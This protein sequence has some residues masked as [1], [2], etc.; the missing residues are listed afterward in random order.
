MLINKDHIS[1]TYH[2][3]IVE[4]ILHDVGNEDLF[5]PHC[6][7]F[8]VHSIGILPRLKKYDNWDVN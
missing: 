2:K 3:L 8:T 7:L 6:A 1:Y 5:S 4:I